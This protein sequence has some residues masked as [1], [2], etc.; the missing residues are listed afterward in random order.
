MKKFLLMGVVFFAVA[1]GF[2]IPVAQADVASSTTMAVASS[3]LQAQIDT[4]NQ[5]IAQLNQQIAEYQAELQQAGA[6]KKTLQSAI[7]GLDLQKSKVQAQIAATEHQ[8]A[9]TQLQIQQIGGQIVGTE[10]VIATQQAALGDELVV[11]EKAESQSLLIQLLRSATLV[12][13]WSDT[14]Q[15]LQVQ[16]A[17]QGKMQELR[18]EENNLQ[19]SKTASQEK[20]TTLTSQQQSL[21]AQQQSLVATEQSKTQLLAETNAK[22]STYQ[23]LLAAAE[24]ELNSFSTFA[25]NAGGSKLLAGQ[26]SCDAWGCYYNQRDALWG[27]NALD[28]TK[29]NIASDGCLISAVA[30]VMTHYGYRDVT[31]ATINADP[32]NFAAY[33][34]AYLL[35]TIN[36]D[37]V[38]ATRKTAA[39]DA[40][41]STGNPVIIGLHAYGGTHFVV[42][43]SGSKGNYTMRDP[44]IT[45]GKDISFSA[46]Y[47]MKDVFG[48]TKVVIGR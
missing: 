10:Q 35:T 19:D 5:Q 17:I 46:N 33:Y 43:V 23:K 25:Q 28:G 44:Y 30:M 4:N 39:I 18:A 27:G 34:P 11:L 24:A 42:F 20:Q 3:S 15:T 26:T 14:N 40:T 16:D 37:G 31:P 21:A 8:I 45:D 2:S 36:V 41:L 1:A 32:A 47:S 38:S 48:V 12:E 22:E 29:Y 6:D 7:K 13:A 9:V